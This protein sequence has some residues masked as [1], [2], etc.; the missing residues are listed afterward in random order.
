MRKMMKQVGKQPGLL[1]KL[2]GFKQMNML[3]KAKGGQMD[4]LF[5]GMDDLG[6]GDLKGP[7]RTGVERS[8][9]K[10]VMV[11]RIDAKKNRRSQAK[12]AAKARK[13]NKKR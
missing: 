4:G 1:N 7:A 3:R 8:S 11:A 13:K 6:L 5:D 9:D 12:K 10:Q 2:P